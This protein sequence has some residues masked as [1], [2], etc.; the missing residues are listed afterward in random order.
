MY[1]SDFVT[2][3]LLNV[4][5]CLPAYDLMKQPTFYFTYILITLYLQF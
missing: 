1:V 5:R 4:S 3:Y 2:K